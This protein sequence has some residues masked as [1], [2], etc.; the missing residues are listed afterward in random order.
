MDVYLTKQGNGDKTIIAWEISNR[1]TP[2]ETKQIKNY[3]KLYRKISYK[4]PQPANDDSIWGNKM[5]ARDKDVVRIC[6]EHINDIITMQKGNHKLD[7]A[8]DTERN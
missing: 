2:M 4:V 1:A 5:E 6:M 8:V 7:I 3:E